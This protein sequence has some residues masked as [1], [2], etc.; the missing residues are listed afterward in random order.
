ME[1]EVRGIKRVF[2]VLFLLHDVVTG[3]LAPKRTHS[4]FPLDRS[5]PSVLVFFCFTKGRFR[6]SSTDVLIKNKVGFR[7]SFTQV[8]V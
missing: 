6:H 2:I 7:Y 3:K 1:L 8:N 5:P 4:H